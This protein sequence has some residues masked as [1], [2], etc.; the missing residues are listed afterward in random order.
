MDCVEA[1]GGSGLDNGGDGDFNC[2][3]C[4]L[5]DHGGG[6]VVEN[7]RGGGSLGDGGGGGGDVVENG[8]VGGHSTIDLQSNE[9]PAP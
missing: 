3:G 2:H 4:S 5:V 6:E 7:G 8:A 9:S 1:G